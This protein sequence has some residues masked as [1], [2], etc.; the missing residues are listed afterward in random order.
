MARSP[1]ALCGRIVVDKGLCQQNVMIGDDADL[2]SF[3]RR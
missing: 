3:P 1:A 2:M